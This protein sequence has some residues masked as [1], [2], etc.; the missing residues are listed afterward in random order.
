MA[1]E[2]DN[3]ADLYEPIAP[4]NGRT[5]IY[6]GIAIAALVALIG[7][8]PAVLGF[9]PFGYRLF[10]KDVTIH[11]LNVSG[12]NVVVT[13]SF[14]SPVESPAGSLHT[15]KSLSGPITIEAVDG[16]GVVVDSLS[17]NASSDVLYNVAGGTCFAVFDATE[18][19][20][21]V[22]NPLLRVAARIPA[23][24]RLYDIA[25][26]TVVL[27]RRPPPAQAVGTVHWIED[28]D[29][30]SLDPSTESDLLTW[31]E[32]RMLARFER[33]QEAQERQQQGP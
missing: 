11:I 22:D 33:Q 29:C 6:A 16:S 31:A 17:H 18:F 9:G 19:Y 14:A 21:G 26:A 2:T 20:S 25:A 5:R 27:P 24:Q 4:S 12:V 8:I 13:A 30:A 15:A 7:A 3:N 10:G 32:Y 1:D 23:A 28:V